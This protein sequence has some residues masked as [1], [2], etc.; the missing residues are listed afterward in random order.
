MVRFG[1]FGKGVRYR[2]PAALVEAAVVAEART[3]VALRERIGDPTDRD[4]VPGVAPG[5]MLR[6]VVHT[7]RWVLPG[8]CHGRRVHQA[9]RP[10]GGRRPGPGPGRVQWSV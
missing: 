6:F 1:V 9:H 5:T 4:P 3:L 8:A 7:I 2:L 10:G